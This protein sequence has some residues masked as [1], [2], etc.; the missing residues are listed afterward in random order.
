MG[1][2]LVA[3]GL[4]R[5]RA[6]EVSSALFADHGVVVRPF[7]AAGLNSLRVSPNLMNTDQELDLLVSILE[8]MGR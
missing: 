2:M 5:G 8:E 7:P 1:A 3:V 4:E 6:D